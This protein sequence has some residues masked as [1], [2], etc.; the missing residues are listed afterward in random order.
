MAPPVKASRLYAA[1]CCLEH[2]VDGLELGMAGGLRQGHTTLLDNH[3]ELLAQ[4]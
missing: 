3:L 2:L 4:C 1:S